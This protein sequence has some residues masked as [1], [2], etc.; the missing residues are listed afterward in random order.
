MNNMDCKTCRSRFP[1]SLFEPDLPLDP[2]L[3]AHLDAC[4]PCKA[5]LDEMRATFLLLDEWAAPEPSPYFDSRVRAHLREVVAAQPES[6]WERL[7]GTLRFSTGLGL[8][9]ALAGAFLLILVLGGGTVATLME[10]HHATPAAS[11]TVNDLKI[12]DNNAQALQQ[13]DLLDEPGSDAS[14]AAPQS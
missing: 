2:A 3:S 13:M 4:V 5:E 11:P 14:T 9:S 6:L 10:T 7:L 12:Y 1:D 8:R